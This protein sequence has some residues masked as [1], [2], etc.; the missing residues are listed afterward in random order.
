M[1]DRQRLAIALKKQAAL[2]Q[3]VDRAA[4]YFNDTLPQIGQLAIQDYENVGKLARLLG[5]HQTVSNDTVRYPKEG[6]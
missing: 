2:Q 4:V 3:T 6:T 5:V 1:Q